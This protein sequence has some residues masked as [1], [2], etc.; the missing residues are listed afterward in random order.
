MKAVETLIA[1]VNVIAVP[2]FVRVIVGTV[3]APVTVV[4]PLFVTVK[5]FAVKELPRLTAPPVP[6]FTVKLLDPLTAPK[7]IPAPK[8]VMFAEFTVKLPEVSA[9]VPVVITPLLV[10]NEPAPPIVKAPVVT[11][12]ADVAAVKL[13]VKVVLPALVFTPFVKFIPDPN[14]TPPVLENVVEGVI[15]PPPLKTTL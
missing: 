15:V 12:A 11:A 4:L 13:P 14:V 1:P 9:T 10:F 8:F 5:A 6:A 7:L 3:V 2:V